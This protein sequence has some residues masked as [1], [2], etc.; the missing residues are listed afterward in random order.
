MDRKWDVIVV[1][2]GPVG[3]YLAAQLAGWGLD[4]LV[5]EEHPDI[6]RP[7][8]CSGIIG[9]DCLNSFPIPPG[10]V[11]REASSATFFSPSGKT[12]RAAAPHPIAFLVDRPGLDQALAQYAQEQGAVI[13][14]GAGMRGLEVNGHGATVR[15][16]GN[17]HHGLSARAVVLATGFP[18]PL[19]AA[20]GLGEIS[21]WGVGA[22]AEVPVNGLG[23]TEVY[24]GRDIAPG[25]FAWLAPTTPGRA[26]AG[27]I[28]SRPG[29]Y[30]QALLEDLYRRGKIKS[31]QGQICFRRIAFSPL[32]RT[33]GERVLAVGEAAGQVKVTTGGGIFYGL[34]C[35][36]AAANTL[37]EA[38]SSGDLSARSLSRYERA[39]KSRLGPELKVGGWARSLYSRLSDRRIDELFGMLQGSDIVGSVTGTEDFSFDWH[40]PAILRALKHQAFKGLRRLLPFRQAR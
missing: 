31:P 19:P 40:S 34:L 3:S 16:E 36:E 8:C 2:A 25:F 28:S 21:H 38:L 27:V 20:A 1:G 10:V 18:S 30:L 5:L 32:P 37:R 7:S 22:Q 4:T 6:G 33:Y 17:G 15:V 24:L 23:E 29:P 12:L 35:A 13:R 26:L 39:W 14:T 11:L 9:R